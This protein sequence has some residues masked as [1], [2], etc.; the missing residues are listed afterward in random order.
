M[1]TLSGGKLLTLEQPTPLSEIVKRIK[2]Q[3]KLEHIRLAK[4]YNNI[5]GEDPIIRTVGACAGSGGRVLAGVQANLLLT[6]EM[7]H[8]QV[9]E[10]TSGGAAVILCEHTNTERGFLQG[11]YKQRLEEALGGQV[12]V[13]VSTTDKDPLSIV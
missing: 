6:G 7:S 8:H 11:V 10:A 3:L 12:A 5:S 4:P 9:L 1:P 13:T 2:A